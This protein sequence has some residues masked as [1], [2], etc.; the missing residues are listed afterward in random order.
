VVSVTDPYG[1]ILGF[2]DRLISLDAIQKLH[3]A[4]SP[5]LK[6]GKS[7]ANASES[8]ENVN[9]GNRRR[10]SHSQRQMRSEAK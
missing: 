1:L 4:R 7:L 9:M 8:T 6:Q 5:S 3:L 2:L 10:F